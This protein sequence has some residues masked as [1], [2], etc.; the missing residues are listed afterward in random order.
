MEKV[1]KKFYKLNE[2][3]YCILFYLLENPKFKG[4]FI[5]FERLFGYSGAQ[6]DRIR[7]F[8][9]LLIKE[10]TIEADSMIETKNK[11]TFQSYKVNVKGLKKFIED[12]TYC[13][14]AFYHYYGINVKYTIYQP[15]ELKEIYINEK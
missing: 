7:K 3:E 1:E 10:G 15:T 2:E 4:T 9:R 8:L 11:L 12:K 6:G 13:G 14:E 5:D